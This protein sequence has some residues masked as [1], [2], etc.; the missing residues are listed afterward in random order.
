MAQLLAESLH[1]HDKGAEHLLWRSKRFFQGGKD[2]D[3]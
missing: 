2:I 1:G 3:P